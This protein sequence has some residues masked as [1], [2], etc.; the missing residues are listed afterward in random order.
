MSGVIVQRE[1]TDVL[2][3]FPKEVF[4]VP[5]FLLLSLEKHNSEIVTTKGVGADLLC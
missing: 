5:V 4:E 2:L 3:F 1:K